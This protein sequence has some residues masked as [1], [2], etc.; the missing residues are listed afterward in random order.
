MTPRRLLGWIVL[1]AGSF[2]TARGQA[3]PP[4]IEITRVEVLLRAD[5]MST[6]TI[7]APYLRLPSQRPWQNEFFVKV[8]LLT[9]N[10]ASVRAL[11]VDVGFDL[12]MG[13][14]VRSDISDEVLQL[15][16]VDRRGEWFRSAVHY[17]ER[18]EC[19][20]GCAA[21]AVLGPFDL[22]FLIPGPK[23]ELAV[24]WPTRLRV[25]AQA[26]A[27]PARERLESAVPQTVKGSTATLELVINPW[28]KEPSHH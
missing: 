2:S 12:W 28:S 25:H 27:V 14:Q 9:R 26:I 13:P 24:L 21:D 6:P 8:F 7:T 3:L 22:S 5:S 18:I 19:R 20:N 17:Q 10:M 11:D 4:V 23:H 16:E 15:A 1:L